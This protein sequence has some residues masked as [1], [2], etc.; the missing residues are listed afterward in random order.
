MPG[1]YSNL[2]DIDVKNKKVFVRVD[3]NVP[4][5]DGKVT[6]TTRIDAT[7]KTL[8]Y[9]T[10]HDGLAIVASHLGKPKGK[11][12]NLS[13]RPIAPILEAKIGAKTIMA[14]DCVGENVKKIIA[15]EKRG[16]RIILLDNLRYHKGEEEDGP[17]FIEELVDLGADIYVD[18]AFGTA[19]RKHASN[20]GLPLRFKELGKI[21]APGYCMLNEINLWGPILNTKRGIAI[22][23]GAKLEEKIKA[24]D[25][26]SKVFDHVILG[27]LVSHFFLKASGLS[28][29]NAPYILDEK[30]AKYIKKAEEIL[31][32]K[33]GPKL[34]LPSRVVVADY[35]FKGR[36]IM[37]PKD[38]PDGKMAVDVLSSE[39]NCELIGKYKTC[40]WFGPPGAF[41][42]E[43]CRGGT[44]LIV[45]AIDSDSYC[46]IGGGDS[47]V[48]AKDIK[49]SKVS[50]GGGASIEYILNKDLPALEALR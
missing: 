33:Y 48:F 7:I 41:E 26:F 14:D 12:E 38:I 49:N 11:D 28:M 45:N 25:Y 10:A 35:D 8:D 30:N 18:D 1:S 27:G 29:G 22:V 36:D 43:G 20:Y 3:F 23:G 15:G 9:I 2:E 42:K 31:N 17:E 44:D 21:V 16:G 19:H 37:D 46:V 34:I 40:I 39:E 24:V 32:G 5:K 6:D 47:A 50:T 13:L 4:L